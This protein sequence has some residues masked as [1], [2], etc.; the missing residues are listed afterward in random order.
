MDSRWK[1]NWCGK[2]I[3][4][5]GIFCILAS[6]YKTS[7]CTCL[8][9]HF[10]RCWPWWWC[11]HQQNPCP[12]TMW[13]PQDGHFP[14]ANGEPTYVAFGLETTDVSNC[15][16]DLCFLAHL[17]QSAKV[18]FWDQPVSVVRRRESWVVSRQQF[19]KTSSS[20]K[21]P[22]RKWPNLAWMLLRRSSTKFDQMVPVHCIIRSQE[23]K[24]DQKWGD[25]KKSSSLK[26]QGQ[27]HLY[28][29][30]SIT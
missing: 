6:T 23:L 27:G 2:A 17:A 15:L 26:P 13:F 20:L 8:S 16:V 24:I 21:P 4:F 28:L 18:S 14:M 19:T 30:C 9:S 22:I 5:I 3:A 25:L 11:G 1:F 29:A 10:D 12:C 7:S